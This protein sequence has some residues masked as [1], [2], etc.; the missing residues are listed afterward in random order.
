MYVDLNGVFLCCS[1]RPSPAAAG[2]LWILSQ[3]SLLPAERHSLNT[4][5][6]T[7]LD[8]FRRLHIFIFD[9]MRKRE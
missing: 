6:Y 2:I 9:G 4:T 8:I 5:R 3:P 1:A 7:T